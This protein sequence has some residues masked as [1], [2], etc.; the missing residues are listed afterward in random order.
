MPKLTAFFICNLFFVALIGQNLTIDGYVY[1][2]GNRGFLNVVQIKVLDDKDKE[3]GQVFSDHTG[4][5]EISVPA[6]FNYK[7]VAFKDMFEEIETLL[8]VKGE[9]D[10][11]KIFTKIEMRRAPGYMFEITLAENREHD[12]IVVDAIKGARIEVYN[13]TKRE[14]VL[15]LD[16]HP[17]PEFDVALHKGNH[18]TILVRK[19][20]YLGKRMEAFVD[21]EGCI[22]CFEGIGSV[23]PGVADNLTEGN[24]FGVLLANVGL[25]K[26]YE[27]KTIPIN[28]INYE[29][30]SAELDGRYED[31]LLSLAT[32]MK[33]NPDLTVEIGSHTDSRGGSDRNFELSNE[34]ARSVVDF[35]VENGVARSRLLS[36]GYGE[37]TLLNDCDNTRECS[38]R[39]HRVNRRTELKVI[40]IA[41]VKA[42]IKTLSQI[43][44][45]EQGE[46][47]L[48]DIQF[49]GEIQIPLDSMQVSEDG[50]DLDSI[51][52]EL[53]QAKELPEQAK[54]L[55]ELDEETVEVSAVPEMEEVTSEVSAEIATAADNPEIVETMDNGNTDVETKKSAIKNVIAREIAPENN[56]EHQIDP[57]A[58]PRI[59]STYQIVINESEEELSNDNDIFQRHSNL[60]II[61]DG[62]N[63]Y[64]YLIGEFNNKND[65]DRFFSTVKLAY[66]D[67]YIVEVVKG[68]IVK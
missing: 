45:M 62:D 52:L 11:N 21:V 61:A 44:Q 1:E 38:D 16:S 23:T 55:P 25:E 53:E 27:G 64:Y 30:G 8:D 63:N 56:L 68:A 2:S 7:V 42:P 14:E 31:G 4:H 48:E 59:G 50:M 57:D 15:V 60:N 9:G 6:R 13:N 46:A 67:S 3:L 49:G 19:D 5:F 41:P 35:L 36:R 20:G 24:E 34:R 58:V 47:L 17:H 32:I 66:P 12:S 39:L 22:L 10:G 51:T 43:K 65:A 37:T 40:G 33:D 54:E 29:F 26:I 18:Y 28:N